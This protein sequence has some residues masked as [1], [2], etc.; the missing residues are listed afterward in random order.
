MASDAAIVR[1]ENVSVNF[2]DA[3]ALENAVESASVLRPGESVRAIK[4]AFHPPYRETRR[5]RSIRWGS[6]SGRSG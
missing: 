4:A 2:G 5:L 6:V 3:P 1:F